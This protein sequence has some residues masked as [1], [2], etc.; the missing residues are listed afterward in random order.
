MQGNLPNW[1]GW[2]F[3]ELFSTHMTPKE[4]NPNKTLS[5]KIFSICVLSL[6]WCGAKVPLLNFALYPSRYEHTCLSQIQA[7][8]NDNHL[9]LYPGSDQLESLV[10]GYKLSHSLSWPLFLSWHNPGRHRV[11]ILPYIVN[12][13]WELTLCVLTWLQLLSGSCL[14]NWNTHEVIELLSHI[15][16]EQLSALHAG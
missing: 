10:V 4:G 14:K 8:L 11:A 2:I 1:E 7:T 5:Q 16:L 3:S 12:N 6:I 13:G 15:K 9:G